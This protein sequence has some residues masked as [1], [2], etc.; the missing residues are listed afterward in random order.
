MKPSIS[1]NFLAL[2][3]NFEVIDI[4]MD[5]LALVVISEFDDFFFNAIVNKEMTEVIESNAYKELLVWQTTTSYNARNIMK[6]NRLEPQRCEEEE[7]SKRMEDVE[8]LE[9]RVRKNDAIKD[10]KHKVKTL[11]VSDSDQSE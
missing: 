11:H 6:G 2:L 9:E 10:Y 1:F 7:Y 5:F 3:T 8:E 4:V